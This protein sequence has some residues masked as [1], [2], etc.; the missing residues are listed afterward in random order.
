MMPV[1]GGIAGGARGTRVVEWHHEFLLV[2][3]QA[4][5]VLG[6][7]VSGHAVESRVLSAVALS[8]S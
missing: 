6:L 4:V 2:A 8:I 7:E 1:G 3:M 5:G